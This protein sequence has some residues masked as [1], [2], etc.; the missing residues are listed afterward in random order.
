[1]QSGPITGISAS[2]LATAGVVYQDTPATA[3]GVYAGN[4]G[5]LGL[6]VLDALPDNY[7]SYA[8]DGLDDAWQ[9]QYF[10][11]NNPNAAPG[12]V[13][14]GSGLT[15]LFKKRKMKPSKIGPR[16]ETQGFEPE[17][18]ILESIRADSASLRPQS[19]K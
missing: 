7:G 15:N 13:S 19:L 8:G 12:H 16:L 17:L 4:T 18:V 5:T 2:G 6:T 9:N 3:Q 10:G 14:D 11:L 1:M